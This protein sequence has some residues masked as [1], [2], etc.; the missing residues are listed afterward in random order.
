MKI[1]ETQLFKD[2]LYV[3]SAIALGSIIQGTMDYFEKK[4]KMNALE[5]AAIYDEKVSVKNLD[6]KYGK[7]GSILHIKGRDYAIKE[8]SGDFYLVP[9]AKNSAK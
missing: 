5:K 8:L 6:L 1:D 4:D 3:F 7:S 2:F 9:Y